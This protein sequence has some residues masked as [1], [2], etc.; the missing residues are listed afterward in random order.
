MFQVKSENYEQI[1]TSLK[2]LL[3]SIKNINEIELIGNVYQ[4][5]KC[6]GGD[7]KFLA[8]LYGLNAA[9]SDYPCIWCKCNITEKLD[10][11]KLKNWSISDRKLA[12]SAKIIQSGRASKG[13]IKPPILNFIDFDSVILDMLH[14]YLRVTDRF[15]E[16]IGTL[17]EKADGIKSSDFILEKRPCFKRYMEFLENCK[18]T[19]PFYTSKKVISKYKLRSLN[20]NERKL[21]LGKLVETKIQNLF[22][23]FENIKARSLNFVIKSFM[24]TIEKIRKNE[25]NETYLDNLKEDLKI[26]LGHYVKL[27][28]RETKEITP[29]I[30]I[31][32]FH[33]PEFI[34]KHKNINIYN[35]QGL[36]KLND[37]VTQIYHCSSNKHK[38]NNSYIFQM[39]K[40]RNRV[41]F[42]GING[43]ED[44]LNILN[45]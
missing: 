3:D 8:L 28:P 5:K 33:L 42:Y 22:P 13:Y 34:Q 37:F 24:D 44:D 9:N 38:L 40:K 2:E 32:T 41:D 14:L 21:I 29:Y 20:S 39:I 7:L 6:F 19:N 23:E 36:E 27:V 31:F 17:I 25:F 10:L 26:W 35:L 12:E 1:E 43:S 4:I 11:K 15:F 30:H 18:I 45:E 16:I